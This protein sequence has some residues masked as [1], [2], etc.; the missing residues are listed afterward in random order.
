MKKFIASKKVFVLL[1]MLTIFFLGFYALNLT[2]PIFYGWEYHNET[3]YDDGVFEGNMTFYSSNMM[4]TENTNLEAPIESYYYYN[5]GDIF[6][7]LATTEEEY[8]TE[9]AWINE[10]YEE[11]LNTPFYAEKINVFELVCQEADGYT[12]VY[13]CKEATV[14][15]I[16]GG[17]VELILIVITVLSFILGRKEKC[18]NNG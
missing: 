10:N 4:V 11:A 18:K 12:M 9:V 1:L 14:F 7:T 13:T 3:V 2:R 15:A 6:F 17:I 5:D 8:K 16:A